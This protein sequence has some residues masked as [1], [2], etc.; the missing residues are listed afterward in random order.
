M[1][2]SVFRGRPQV[3]TFE[4]DDSGRLVRTVVRSQ[5]TEEDRALMMARH[6]HRRSL[7]SGC[8]QPREK[9]W[10]P[11][12]DGWFEV[13]DTITCHACTAERRHGS[14]SPSEVKPVEFPVVTY[15]RDETKKPLPSMA[16][17][18]P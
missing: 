4:Y 11:D 2:P 12:N 3:T 16:A 8:G 9:A 5:W 15:T 1:S 18:T 7:C 14:D 13:T 17:M 6:M 10:H